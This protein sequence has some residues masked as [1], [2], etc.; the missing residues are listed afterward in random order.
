M[1]DTAAQSRRW[2]VG[3]HYGIHVYEITN[4]E[5]GTEND[6]RPVATFHTVQDARDAVAAFNKTVDPEITAEMARLLSELDRHDRHVVTAGKW[7]S[8]MRHRV[9]AVLERWVLNG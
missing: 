5:P 7:T 8:G 4:G 2:R 6:D 3:S 1:P 9:L